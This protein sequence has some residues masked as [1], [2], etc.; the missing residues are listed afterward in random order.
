MT[1]VPSH[2]KHDSEHKKALMIG[3]GQICHQPTDSLTKE[4]CCTHKVLGVAKTN[5]QEAHIPCSGLYSFLF[6]L[7]EI[8]ELLKARLCCGLSSYSNPRFHFPLKQHNDKKQDLI[9]PQ[10]RFSLKLIIHAMSN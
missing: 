10:Q 1:N 9:L 8:L 2:Q 3:T 5:W 6:A 4:S 7:F